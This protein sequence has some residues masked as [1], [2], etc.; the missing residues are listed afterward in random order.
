VV[1]RVEEAS[2]GS[3][4][5]WGD[6]KPGVPGGAFGSLNAS[7]QLAELE[8]SCERVGEAVFEVEIPDPIEVHLDGLRQ[9]RGK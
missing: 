1:G 7:E 5:R 6:W 4:E 3:E 8:S 2:K 9:M